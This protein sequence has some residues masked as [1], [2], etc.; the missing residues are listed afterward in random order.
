MQFESISTNIKGPAWF[1][2]SKP[3]NLSLL[4]SMNAL[5]MLEKF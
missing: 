2:L 4:L 5:K 3:L 1:L